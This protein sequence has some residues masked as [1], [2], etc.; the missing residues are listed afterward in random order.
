MLHAHWTWVSLA[1][2]SRCALPTHTHLLYLGMPRIIRPYPKSVSTKQC[3]L[4]QHK[5]NTTDSTIRGV[6]PFPSALHPFVSKWTLSAGAVRIRCDP[7]NNA[8]NS[9]D[10]STIDTI[11]SARRYRCLQI[12]RRL[13]IAAAQLRS[14]HRSDAVFARP[15]QLHSDRRRAQCV[16]RRVAVLP[17]AID[18][19]QSIH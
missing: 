7:H 8:R 2:L 10:G 16:S 12:P 15:P 5:D 4:R 6:C 9:S 14:A 1:T 13:R 19:V 17:S 11:I 18:V 3:T